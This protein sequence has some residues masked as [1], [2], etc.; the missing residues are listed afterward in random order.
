[1][2][3]TLYVAGTGMALAAHSPSHCAGRYLKG[4]KHWAHIDVSHI[5]GMV[6]DMEIIDHD[7]VSNCGF[8]A[9]DHFYQSGNPRGKLAG[10]AARPDEE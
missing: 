8:I 2:G 10:K 5:A 9:F 3:V 1:M 4:D 7:A 6:V